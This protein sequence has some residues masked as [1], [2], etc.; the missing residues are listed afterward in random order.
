MPK[1]GYDKA[2]KEGIL[3]AVLEARK[4]GKKWAAAHELAVKAGYKGSV[5]GIKQMMRNAKKHSGKQKRKANKS[6]P[7]VKVAPPA[8]PKPKQKAD[9]IAT[10]IEDLVK[11]RMNSGLDEAIAMLR[12]MRK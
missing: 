11:A 1:L 12:Q 8:K 3:K 4:A 5:G 2:P 9:D 6:T 10:L 7:V